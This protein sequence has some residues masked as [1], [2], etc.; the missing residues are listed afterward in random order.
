M[1][2]CAFCWL[3]YPHL[4]IR[5]EL[6]D[7]YDEIARNLISGVGYHLASGDAWSE[8]LPVVPFFYAAHMLLFGDVAWPWQLTQSVLG[9]LTCAAVFFVAREWADRRSAFVAALVCV[10]HPLLV[11]YVARPFTE[12]LYTLFLLLFVVELRRNDWSAFRSGLWYGL[13][14]LTK[15]IALAH[16]VAFAGVLVRAPRR[17]V[18]AL[19]VAA[20]VM[21]P[22]IAWNLRHSGVANLWSG[23]AGIALYHGVFISRHAGWTTPVDDLNRDAELALWQDLSLQG[24]SRDSPLMV[25]DHVARHAAMQWIQQHRGEALQLW[26]RN[27]I[28]TWYLGRSRLSMAVYA[29]LHGTLLSCALIGG[30]RLWRHRPEIRPMVLGVFVLTAFYTGLHAAVQPAVRYVL[31]LVPCLAVLAAASLGKIKKTDFGVRSR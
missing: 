4:A 17:V 19:V 22:W 23:H 26:L 16:V 14:A 21:T 18:G 30:L 6:G 3:I 5:L 11:L 7:G 15:N 10:F 25:R 8:R 12:T 27:L 13:Q 9:A 20:F 1:V 24:A 29:L 28:L 2:R 31:P